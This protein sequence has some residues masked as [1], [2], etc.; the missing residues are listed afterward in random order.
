MDCRRVNSRSPQTASGAIGSTA[1]ARIDTSSTAFNPQALGRTRP[2]TVVCS[3]DAGGSAKRARKERGP[4]WN[5][6]EVNALIEA[7]RNL[8][9]HEL[10]TVDGRQLMTPDAGKWQRISADVMKEGHSP[11]HRDGPACKSK[12]NQ[13][14]PDYKKIADFLARTGNNEATYWSL[15]LAEKTAEG[16]PRFYPQ[17]VFFQIHSWY[18]TR[19]TVM[20]PH[21]RDLMCADDSNFGSPKPT[22]V[23]DEDPLDGDDENDPIAA[24]AALDIADDV[25]VSTQSPA[26]AFG[27]AKARAV[28]GLPF[29]TDFDSPTP[30][31]KRSL[32]VGVTPQLLSSSV[33]PRGTPRRR[34]PNTG[35]RRKSLSGHSLIAD[36]T[37][38]TGDAMANQMR[39]IAEASRE[40]EKARIE[41]QQ[42][43]FSEQMDYQKLKDQRLQ[44]NARLANENAKLAIE[45]QAE[46]VSCLAQLSS[47]LTLGFQR[48]LD[49]AHCAGPSSATQLDRGIAPPT[50]R[51]R[52]QGDPFSGHDL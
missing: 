30:V 25:S 27:S 5:A 46:V 19:P 17:D 9:V 13:L 20:P 37:R 31:R 51:Q 43:I 52:Q 48:R 10:E 16:L 41:V 26:A 23:N 49:S 47:A 3:L 34:P 28:L 2:A 35:I 4:N 39:D 21:T 29:E 24:A 44:E 12:W 22:D 36:A 32:P 11:C 40:L 18:G 14:I 45:K 50:E 7:K 6:L 1:A 42:R 15:S 8:F 33:T 38:A